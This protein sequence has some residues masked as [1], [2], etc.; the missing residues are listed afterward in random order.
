MD[1]L[2]RDYAAGIFNN[3]EPPCL[4][5]YQPTHRV[6]PD[7]E[8][9]PIRF[10]NLVKE[11]EHSLRRDYS[12]RDIRHLIEPF[13]KL[14]DDRAFWN[15]TLTGL[16]A[17]GAPGFFRAYRLRR[18]VPELAIVADSFHLKPLLRI[19][20]SADDYQLL[21]VSQEKISFFEGNRDA[22][23]EV[24]LDPI[25]PRS[26]ADV[27]GGEAKEF[28]LSAWTS[29]PRSPGLRYSE[30]SKS[31]LVENDATRFFRAVDRAILERYSRP[32][33]LPLLLAALPENQSL[34]RRISH[35]PFLVSE[36]IN[37]YPG[38]LSPD[39]LCEQAW[40]V[41]QPHYLARLAGLTEIF[42]AAKPRGLSSDNLEQIARSAVA[43][44]VATLLVE[45]DRKIPGRFDTITGEIQFE[46]LAKPN[47]D[48]VLDDIAELVLKNGGQ[49]VVVPKERMPTDSGLAAIY[50]F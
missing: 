13:H 27:P 36:P 28:H 20:Q 7:N 25:V 2:D 18:A 39:A 46:E 34:F 35:N 37:F 50:R 45:A 38:D 31:D 10:R 33:R 30:G 6:H 43:A 44:R 40:E 1:S 11:L 22:L 26:P 8:Q 47:V 9:D 42:G 16:A 5:L 15:S 12:S 24:E 17:L 21:G 19:L 48:D 32:S 41:L 14:A 29:S 3:P 23:D 4:S 49:V